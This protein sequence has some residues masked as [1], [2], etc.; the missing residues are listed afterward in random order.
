MVA[1][2]FICRHAEGDV[3]SRS[4]R[5]GII[6]AGQGTM[7]RLAD[8]ASGRAGPCDRFSRTH[9]RAT[10]AR[11][12]RRARPRPT[13]PRPSSWA[14]DRR[15]AAVATPSTSALICN[16]RSLRAA[17]PAQRIS[18]AE[19]RRRKGP[20][21][22]RPRH[23]P[24]PPGCSGPRGRACAGASGPRRPLPASVSPTS[25]LSRNPSAPGSIGS[26]NAVS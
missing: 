4:D 14:R 5:L 23:R 22:D 26:A 8:D 17:P 6:L 13:W 12:R 10:P 21:S 19:G 24:P 15:V 25:V 3:L 20:P 2:V 16:H 18:R 7:S 9:R 11:R 1:T